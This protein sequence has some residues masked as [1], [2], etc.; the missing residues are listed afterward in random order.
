MQR[1]NNRGLSKD[2]QTL[3]NEASQNYKDTIKDK[4][5]VDFQLLPPNIHIRNTAE[6]AIRTFKAHFLA[7]LLGVSPDFNQFLWDILLM[8]TKITLKFLRQSTFN[9]TISAWEYFAGPFQYDTTPLGCLGM[10][11]I[12]HKKD[13]QRH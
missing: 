3:E 13:Y 12:I 11:V 5:G 9:Q 10:N 1:L 7:V 4:W 2:L 6:P 8:Q